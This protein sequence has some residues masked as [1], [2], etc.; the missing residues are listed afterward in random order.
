MPECHLHSASP[1]FSDGQI[2]NRLSQLFANFSAEPCNGI[3]G[4][5]RES[6]EEA[7]A[8][9]LASGNLSHTEK[10]FSRTASALSK[11]GLWKRPPG[12]PEMEG[13]LKLKGLPELE[14]TRIG[15]GARIG[16]G[17]QFWSKVRI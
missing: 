3:N 2:A 10:E 7:R 15:E 9:G 11:L 8:R 1:L 6:F 14:G 4:N 5:V 12:T 17:C 16:R 13:V